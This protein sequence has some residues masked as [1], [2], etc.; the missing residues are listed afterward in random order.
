MTE[1]IGEERQWEALTHDED[2]G[3]VSDF[4]RA[5]DLPAA[6]KLIRRWG[7]F[8][9]A[10]QIA[11]LVQ[12]ERA[13]DFSP[14]SPRVDRYKTPISVDPFDVPGEKKLNLLLTSDEIMR[15]NNQVKISEAFMGSYKTEKTFASTDGSYIEQE[16]TECGAGISATAIDGGEVQV[17]SYPNSFRGNF[18]TKGF[19]W[20]EN[21][22]LQ[23][24]AGRVGEEAVRL[25]WPNPVHRR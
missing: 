12:G 19:E 14:S 4:I 10:L 1:E 3:L 16:I 17:R 25:L 2:W 23:D 13:R 6:R 9:K 11:R 22:A 5:W 20:I 7:V 24:Q 21:L 8:G 15:R 18:A